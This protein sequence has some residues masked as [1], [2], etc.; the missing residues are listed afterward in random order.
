MKFGIKT[1]KPELASSFILFFVLIV[2]RTPFL[3]SIRAVIVIAV[4]ISGGSAIW[5]FVN[6]RQNTSI[7][8]KLGMGLAIGCGLSTITQFCLR[9]TPADSISWLFPLVFLPLGF[10]GQQNKIENSTNLDAHE[11]KEEVKLVVTSIFFLTLLAMSTVWWFLYPTLICT[12]PLLVCE[13]KTSQKPSGQSG[14]K[15]RYYVLIL[16]GAIASW[17]LSEVNDIWIFQSYDQVFSE[18]LSWSI[19][20]RGIND[21]P[22]A[23]G[24]PI[25]YHWFVLLLSGI[26]SRASHAESWTSITRVIPII[27]FIGIFS[28]TWELTRKLDARK[29]A[30]LFAGSFI[31]LYS[32]YFASPTFLFSSVW[33]LAFIVSAFAYF[34]KPSIRLV[35]LSSFLLFLTFGGKIMSG[36][37]AASGY[38][39]ALLIS[40][41]FTNKRL[42]KKRTTVPILL[43]L[44]MIALIF[45]IFNSNKQP[46]NLN[47]LTI[48]NS[49]P[50]ELLIVPVSS[51]LLVNTAGNLVFLLTTSLPLIG[52]AVIQL[53]KS[54]RQDHQT[55][56]LIGAVLSGIMLTL[57]TSHPG[58]SQL[59]FWLASMMIA[60][61]FTSLLAIPN[62]I[63]KKSAF[64]MLTSATAG[65]VLA[66]FGLELWEISLTYEPRISFAIK[67][68]TVLIGPMLIP[69]FIILSRIKR[70][71]NRQYSKLVMSSVI[72]LAMIYTNLGIGLINQVQAAPSNIGAPHSNPTDVNLISG[73][74]DQIEILKWLRQNTETS[75]VIAT[76]RFCIPGP[77]SCISKWQLVS[78]L[79]HR[80]M[81]F[82]GGY[83]TIPNIPDK[84]LNSR[85][86]LSS[87]F[88]LN[89]SALGLKRLCEYGVKWYFF[90]HSVSD[91]LKTWE[92][93]SHIQLQNKGVS[94]LKLRCPTN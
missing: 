17:K 58:V 53:R 51:D 80:R 59:Y 76:N 68:G 36:A 94:L 21:S 73:S 46:G 15:F 77:Q 86:V 43:A 35:V 74:T 40:V 7:A 87:E 49:L 84:E 81:L 13:F 39:C 38:F 93:Y 63:S 79:S 89:P 25:S 54:T 30:P 20:E 71:R 47:K 16:A 85:Y 32:N 82:E 6:Q 12:V 90:D 37:I 3:E 1:F 11:Q 50:S 23:A 41:A 66:F 26:I 9:G 69:I 34:K 91:P 45:Q 64:Y 24:T 62:S 31:I 44:M 57:F 70:D 61:A 48:S 72:G 83:F 65:V 67:L 22:F 55:W 88:G 18:S 42:G 56:F 10:S 14:L 75:D 33:M 78:A 92:P 8:S 28:L 27:S 29:F 60:S 4:Q 2:S 19:L 5:C 52:V